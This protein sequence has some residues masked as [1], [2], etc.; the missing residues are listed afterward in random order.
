MPADATPHQRRVRH[1]VEFGDGF[2]RYRLTPRMRRGFRSTFPEDQEWVVPCSLML[3]EGKGKSPLAG[4]GSFEAEDLDATAAERKKK[5]RAMKKKKKGND[6]ENVEGET[7]APPPHLVTVSLHYTLHFDDEGSDEMLQDRLLNTIPGTLLRYQLTSFVKTRAAELHLPSRLVASSQ[8]TGL[9]HGNSVGQGTSS[10]RLP[11]GF[12]QIYELCDSENMTL[13]RI[14]RSGR[15]ERKLHGVLVQFIVLQMAVTLHLL[16]CSNVVLN[17]ATAPD[18]TL[19]SD[20]TIR[21]CEW[22]LASPNATLA[23]KLRPGQRPFYSSSSPSTSAEV[24]IRR[25]R[26]ADKEL[27]TPFLERCPYFSN[28]WAKGACL[29]PETVFSGNYLLNTPADDM[30]ALGITLLQ[31][32]LGDNA[33]LGILRGHSRE[34]Q[35]QRIEAFLG[36][37]TEAELEAM[38]ASTETREEWVSSNRCCS[39]SA[40]AL[41]ARG[42]AFRAKMESNF[43]SS[44]TSGDAKV[45]EWSVSD[46][47]QV[48]AVLA[49]LLV[50]DPCKRATA[51]EV[52]R[53]PFLAF[54]VTKCTTQK[55]MGSLL[56]PKLDACVANSRRPPPPPPPPHLTEAAVAHHSPFL[57][58][59]PRHAF[60]WSP[61][62]GL[63]QGL[64]MAAASAD[65]DPALA[66]GANELQ[67]RLLWRHVCAA[68]QDTVPETR[69]LG[70]VRLPPPSLPLAVRPSCG[71]E[72]HDHLSSPSSLPACACLLPN[73]MATAA[74]FTNGEVLELYDGADVGEEMMN[75]CTGYH[76]SS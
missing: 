36:P 59:S 32:A 75:I 67:R 43:A 28:V 3:V 26:E 33:A 10:E 5:K 64:R 61:F 71:P 48:V 14:M 54:A 39:S 21:F 74:P 17:A 53:H 2:R 70:G 1:H 72:D 38:G 55:M 19:R 27:A 13:S 12:V 68:H 44:A 24:A 40:C 6:V 35:M 34:E 51:A 42:D 29:S 60:D 47:E 20:C 22:T 73:V 45:A 8:R 9:Y 65:D 56:D 57:P 11:S 7:A 37:P 23:R 31:M 62:H 46:E 52:L 58:P 66:G 63:S 18:I 4:V 76:T 50:Y 15:G 41:S 16:H 30:W 69:R 49:S 25:L